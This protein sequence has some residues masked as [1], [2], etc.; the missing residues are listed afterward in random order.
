MTEQIPTTTQLVRTLKKMVNSVRHKDYPFH[1]VV[2]TGL[3]RKIDKWE[4]HSFD[5]LEDGVCFLFDYSLSH[6][7]L[8]IEHSDNWKFKKLNA[9]YVALVPSTNGNTNI[10]EWF[11]S[12]IHNL[13]GGGDND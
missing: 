12:S 13:L 1:L 6:N 7:V 10:N 2:Y 5:K 3:T 4:T 8:W 9:I 11:L